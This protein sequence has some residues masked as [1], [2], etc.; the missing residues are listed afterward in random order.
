M[1]IGEQSE[2]RKKFEQEHGTKPTNADMNAEMLRRIHEIKKYA[3]MH[4]YSDVEP[5]EVIRVVSQQT[6]IVR[7]M[8]TKQTKFPSKVVPGGFAGHTVDNREGQDYEYTS[9]SANPEIR[10]RW[11]KANRRWQ[12][13]GQRFLMSD[14]P[15][16]FYDYNF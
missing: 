13:G 8:E 7:A 6:V 14:A 2:F 1:N 9:N 16:K 15:Y 3:N 11:S 5:Y 10:I 4:G 12:R